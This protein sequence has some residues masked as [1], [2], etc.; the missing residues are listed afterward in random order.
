MSS[1]CIGTRLNLGAC[2]SICTVKTLLTGHRMAADNIAFCA[3][4]LLY[5]RLRVA[6]DSIHDMPSG[7]VGRSVGKGGGDQEKLN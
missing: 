1:G 6:F 3:R 5:R 4:L 2:R 7:T